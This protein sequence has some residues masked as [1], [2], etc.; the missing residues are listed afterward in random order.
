[1]LVASVITDM[2]RGTEKGRER[3]GGEF[4][5]CHRKHTNTIP[6]LIQSVSVCF[7]IFEIYLNRNSL[8]FWEIHLFT[9]FLKVR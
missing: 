8:A 6:V 7:S 4:L 1:M 3:R 2:K 5:E 9:Y